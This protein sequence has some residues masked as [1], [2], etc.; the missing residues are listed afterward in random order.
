[1]LDPFCGTGTT[2]VE[3]KKSGISSVGIEAIPVVHL[4]AKTKT[5]WDID[6]QALVRHA[7]N[8]ATE[9]ERRIEK[10][11]DNLKTLTDEQSKLLITD[12]ISPLPL[13]KALVL[14]EVMNEFSDPFF[15]DYEK[16][17][18]AK[19]LVFAFSNLKFGPEV[20]VS[21]KKKLDSDVVMIWLSQVTE[22]ENNLKFYEG[23]NSASSVVHLGDARNIDEKLQ[24][25]SID[26]VITSPPYPNEKDYSRT[27]RLESVLLG[28][29]NSK[30]DLRAHKENLM[31]SNTRNV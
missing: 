2:L 4:M 30:K 17:A 15:G 14:L 9:A 11:G 19:Q 27:T 3:C 13:H 1:V 24:H 29:I 18:F 21:K 6:S 31:R 26:A 8:I 10:Y 22:M 25:N 5:Q 16:T 20:G 28:F 23:R 7:Q 12:S